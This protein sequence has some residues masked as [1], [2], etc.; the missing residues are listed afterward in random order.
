MEKGRSCSSL[1]AAARSHGARRGSPRQTP[2]LQVPWPPLQDAPLAKKVR[3]HMPMVVS[4]V[5]AA[6]SHGPLTHVESHC[7][8]AGEEGRVH[9]YRWVLGAIGWS[10]VMRHTKQIVW[11]RCVR[12]QER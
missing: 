10:V 5:G 12:R 1:G 6:E 4:Q 11:S 3:V 7:T 8:T 9:K 2:A